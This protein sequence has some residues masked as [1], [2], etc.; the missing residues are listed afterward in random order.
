MK[1]MIYQILHE[2]LG[3]PQELLNGDYDD[4]ALTGPVF[5]LNGR[6]MTYLFLE[7]EKAT[8]KQID[9]TKILHYEFNTI[10]GILKLLESEGGVADDLYPT[11]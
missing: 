2:R 11:H 4:S 5:K 6:G 1:T 3:I 7:I 10:N 9:A 8:H